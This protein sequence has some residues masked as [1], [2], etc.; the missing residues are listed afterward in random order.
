V[1]TFSD[2]IQVTQNLARYQKMTASEPT[3][4]Q[5]TKYYQANIGSIK[6]ADQLVNNTRLFN[7]VM[8]AYGLSDMT[9][10]KAMIKKALE[11]GTSSSSALAYK[12][13]N[14]KITALVNTFNFSSYGESTTQQT[15]VTQGV[16]DKYV[17]QTLENKQGESNPGVQLALYFRDHAAGI[18][19]AYSILADANLLKVVQTTY[20][21]SPYSSYQNIDTQAATFNRLITYSDF[22]DP[23][24]L[25]NFLQRFTA[26][27][28]F[29]NGSAATGSAS[30]G[31]TSASFLLSLQG[32]KLGGF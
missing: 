5:A 28:D 18:S 2:Y 30:G 9:Y 14:S 4:A 6:S 25:D 10:A 21:I 7:Y 31:L 15:A 11:E 13:H 12:L 1:S 16:V 3:I 22:K 17:M 32:L 8:S 27:Y 24:K 29:T 19:D 20:G 23:K 26:Q